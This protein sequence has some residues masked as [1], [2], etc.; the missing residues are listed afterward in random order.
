MGSV[1]DVWVDFNVC[2]RVVNACGC[3]LIMFVGFTWVCHD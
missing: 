3:V 1:F 2:G